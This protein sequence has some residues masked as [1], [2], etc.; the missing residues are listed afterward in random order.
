MWGTGRHEVKVAPQLEDAPPSI[1]P[2]TLLERLGFP[3]SEQ[4]RE[5]RPAAAP[6]SGGH[7]SNALLESVHSGAP[8]D[9]R[10]RHGGQ[11]GQTSTVHCH[12][13]NRHEAPYGEASAL[14]GLQS[15]SMMCRSCI[16]WRHRAHK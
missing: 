13:S 11:T 2:E 5:V 12:T 9:L 4:H 1:S 14:A 8:G 3:R 16:T 7:N 15:Y 6:P 10:T